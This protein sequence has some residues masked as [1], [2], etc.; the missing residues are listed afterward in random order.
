[1]SDEQ[2]R[3]LQSLPHI[4]EDLL[5]DHPGLRIERAEGFVEQ[6]HFRP[7]RQRPHDTDAL[8]HAAR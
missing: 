6:Q 5:H 8:L 1:M 2:H 7:R 4:G 3:N